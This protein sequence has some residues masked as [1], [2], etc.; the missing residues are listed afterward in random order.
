[1]NPGDFSAG[2]GAASSAF[3]D[4]KLNSPMARIGGEEGGL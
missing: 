4:L 3:F 1:M 2:S